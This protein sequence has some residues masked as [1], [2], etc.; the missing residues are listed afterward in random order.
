MPPWQLLQPFFDGF[1][2]GSR[3]QGAA[4][5]FGVSGDAVAMFEQCGGVGARIGAVAHARELGEPAMEARRFQ[6]LFG[7]ELFFRSL[8]EQGFFDFAEDFH[9]WMGL[10]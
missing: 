10:S 3:M 6:A 2:H 1:R 4:S 7:C 9:G 8:A 5:G